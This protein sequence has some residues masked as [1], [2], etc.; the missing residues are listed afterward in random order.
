M[1]KAVEERSFYAAMSI[2]Q[3]NLQL[4]G[5]QILLNQ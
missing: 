4:N 5:D 1:I 2:H 3:C